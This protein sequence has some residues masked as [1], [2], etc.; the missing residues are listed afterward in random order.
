MNGHFHNLFQCR[1]N[2]KNRERL[3]ERE[4]KRAIGSREE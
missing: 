4:R 2:A 1:K 3:R